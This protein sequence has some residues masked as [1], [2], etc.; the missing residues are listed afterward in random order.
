MN[1]LT[2]ELLNNPVRLSEIRLIINDKVL[3]PDSIK[4]EDIRDS[5]V[6]GF[7][8]KRIDAV[9]NE[10]NL[11]GYT[12]KHRDKVMVEVNFYDVS[13]SSINTGWSSLGFYYIDME[14]LKY[15]DFSK[16]YTFSMDDSAILTNV[17]Y[18]QTEAQFDTY[19]EFITEALSQVGLSVKTPPST[20]FMWDKPYLGMNLNRDDIVQIRQI[21]STFAEMNLHVAKID[22]D[23]YV[24]FISPFTLTEQAYT[25]D[26]TQ[27]STLDVGVKEQIINAIAYDRES[28]ND[29]IWRKNETSIEENGMTD[30]V[31]YDNMMID[32]L[33]REE[34]E[35]LLDEWY[36]LITT[37]DP[38][39]YHYYSFKANVSINPFMETISNID[40]TTI[41]G[42]VFSTLVSNIKWD[43]IG[44]FAGEIYTDVLK[45]SLVNYNLSRERI[46]ELNMGIFVDRVNGEITQIVERVE[47]NEENLTTLSN[48]V[49]NT[50]SLLQVEILERQTQG[51]QIIEELGAR[52]ELVKDEFSIN[53]NEIYE[54]MDNLGEGIENIHAYF[55]FTS[56]GM[57]IG[58][59]T[60]PFKVQI[61]NDR[62]SF[63]ENGREIAYMTGQ[64]LFITS[65]TILSSLTLGNHIV[66]KSTFTAGRTIWR[67]A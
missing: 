23:G 28:I 50:E 45:Q 53:F 37:L 39:G 40:I 49:Y 21:I 17:R 63:T 15:D 13:D 64:T 57:V 1:E 35:S 3:L 46:R 18:S 25:L 36:S 38:S 52:I 4:F 14:D 20:L 59:N 31:I 55:T 8:S 6:G 66:E 34:Q 44:G 27:Y 22:K 32:N 10:E 12:F 24:V 65:A 60:S 26:G 43:W 2:N 5:F 54:G 11:D 30:V 7:T 16:N 9:V 47:G 51:D 61:S 29:P 41:D 56:D 19:G 42:E 33:G 62:L 58:K 48:V 67:K